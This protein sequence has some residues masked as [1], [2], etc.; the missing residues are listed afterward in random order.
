MTSGDV[1]MSNTLPKLF[2]DN[3]RR[4]QD[5]VALR[6]K[7]L[8][9]WKR[10]SWL[11]YCDH[12]KSFCL[13][14]LALGLQKGDKVSILG[15]NC[16]EWLYADLAIQSASAITVGIYPTDTEPQVKYII[17]DSDS[18]YVV[19]RDQEQADKVLEVKAGLPHLE[20]IIVIDMKGLRR[21]RDSMIMSF[22]QVEEVGRK[23][24][25]ENPALFDRLVEETRPE[26]TAIIV[27]TSGT[28][29][30]PKG[31]MLTHRN[32]LTMTDAMFSAEPFYDH[33]SL[34]S[35]L[36][37]CH[38]GERMFSFFFAMKSGHAVNF[39]ESVD[40]LQEDLKEISP[41]AFL[42]VPRIWEKMHSHI[43]IKMQDAF[44][45]KRWIFNFSTPV[46][47]RVARF[48]WEGKR[49]PFL[50]KLLYG[51]AY[52]AM[53]RPLRNKLGLLQGRL[54]VSGA[55]PLSPDIMRFF[56]SI[57]IWIKESYGQT[58]MSGMISIHRGNAITPG[59]VGQVLPGIQCKIAHDGEI[60][61][62]GES[63][64]S[65][66]YRNPEATNSTIRDGW[67]YTGDVGEFD[68]EGQ[69]RIKDRKKD[70]IITSGG[71]NITPSEIENKLKFSPYIKEAIIIGDR[72]KYLA[73]L[74]QIELENISNWAQSNRIPF[75]TYKSLAHNERV[76]E[77]IREEVEKVNQGLAR[78]ETI[79]RFKI[80]DKELDHDD[81]ELTATMKVRRSIIE[82]KFNDLIEGMYRG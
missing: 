10:I 57:G 73:A 5:R 61:L 28:T 11:D 69:L 15:D 50:W 40:T 31:A 58:E 30:P 53:F 72:R 2:L 82:R 36:P 29:G 18:R 78:V 43:I 7:D 75:T 32:I 81:D 68:A 17:E 1:S 27:Y 44:P 47:E 65:G 76:Y 71:K 77:L 14:L 46:G 25:T 70:I 9:I 55:A 19:V 33:D 6:E 20:R 63:V 60:L 35:S 74:I 66:Y 41:T 3:V 34:V 39:A 45:L 49:V 56:H 42:N 52:L 13:G 12:V 59:T 4:F 80:L 51:M 67:L 16:P 54:F 62:S 37:L 21:Y 22:A 8:G 64:F 38:V 48:R 23:V 79:K 24:A 26:D